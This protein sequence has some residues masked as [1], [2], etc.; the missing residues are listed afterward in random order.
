LVDDKVERGS[1][2]A[3]RYR[4]DRVL[5]EGGM[6]VVWAATHELTGKQ[7]AIKLVKIAGDAAHKSRMAR[8]ARE[9][10][11]FAGLRARVA[12]RALPVVKA[13]RAE[14]PP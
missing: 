4:L 8:E 7:V 9:R 2:I 1:R 5:G 14:G 11:S 3:D 12:E 10:T 13:W 6:G